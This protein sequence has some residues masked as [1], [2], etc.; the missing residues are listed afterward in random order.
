MGPHNLK[1]K[2]RLFWRS[3]FL[4]LCAM[5]RYKEDCFMCQHGEWSNDLWRNLNTYVR[6]KWPKLWLWY[7]NKFL[8]WR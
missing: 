7:A 1:T 6:K 3:T 8:T 4:T 5:H 2:G